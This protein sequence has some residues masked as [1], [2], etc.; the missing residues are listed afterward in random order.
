M[1]ITPDNF[2]ANPLGWAGNQAGHIF[3]SLV[4]TYW[5]AIGCFYVFGALPFKWLLFSLLAIIYLSLE[6]PQRGSIADTLEDIVVVLAYGGGL[7]IWS[8]SE[9][10]KNSPSVIFN[11]ENSL[12]LMTIITVH[13]ATGMGVRAVQMW[14]KNE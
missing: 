8:M 11:L 10:S 2:Y 6:L 1:K 9:V 14:R 5:F 3:I 13:F 12:P 4:F 7:A